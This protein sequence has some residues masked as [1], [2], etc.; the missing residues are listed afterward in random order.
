MKRLSIVLLSMLFCFAAFSQEQV[1]EQPVNKNAPV[2]T[3]NKL[4]H[5]YGTVEY[6]GNG[7][8]YFSFTNTGKE[9]LILSNAKASCGCTV[10]SWPKTPILPG[11]TD[12]IQVKYSTTRVGQ[13]NK[14]ITV[15][16][17]ANNSP[18]TLRI[19][20]KVL[21]N[22]EAATPAPSTTTTTTKPTNAAPIQKTNSPVKQN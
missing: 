22:P 9:P 8:C 15:T 4:T 2:M 12:S 19:T 18:I 17:N 5:D 21:P 7:V 3:F 13:I 11:Q 16:S 6:Q 14:S 10:P 1:V 20:G